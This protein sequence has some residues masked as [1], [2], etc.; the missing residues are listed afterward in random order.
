MVLGRHS[1]AFEQPTERDRLAARTNAHEAERSEVARLTSEN[2]ALNRKLAA[3]E[4][5]DGI[6]EIINTR[7]TEANLSGPMASAIAEG[8]AELY[9]THFRE[10]KEPKA[11]G[12]VLFATLSAKIS[13]AKRVVPSAPTSPTPAAALAAAWQSPERAEAEFRAR[14]TRPTLNDELRQRRL[15]PLGVGYPGGSGG[16]R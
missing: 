12:T 1:V 14:A 8:V 15:N 7:L 5:F 4:C 3:V 10:G 6:Q 9:W 16:P 11:F 13:E 2:A